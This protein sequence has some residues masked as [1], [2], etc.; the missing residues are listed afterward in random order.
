MYLPIVG[1]IIIDLFGLP[2]LLIISVV[3]MLTATFISKDTHDIY[4]LNR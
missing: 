1:G 3:F 2:L 4:T